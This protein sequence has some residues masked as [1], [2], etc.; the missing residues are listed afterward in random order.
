MHLAF[1]CAF[2]VHTYTM[3]WHIRIE[4]GWALGILATVVAT[5]LDSSSSHFITLFD[6]PLL[7]VSIVN[8]TGTLLAKLVLMCHG[9][10]GNRAGERCCATKKKL[11]RERLAAE[12][13]EIEILVWNLTLLLAAALAA[14][15]PS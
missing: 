14:F 15:L 6:R 1:C 11:Q 2:N 13:V 8:V 4:E 12:Q 9:I 3:S 10:E 5:S 7:S